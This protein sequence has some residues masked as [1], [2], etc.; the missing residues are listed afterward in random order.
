MV[1]DYS[2]SLLAF[3]MLDCCKKHVSCG[4]AATA[5][6][7]WTGC[8]HSV[9]SGCRRSPQVVAAAAATWEFFACSTRTTMRSCLKRVTRV[10]HRQK[11]QTSKALL[12]HYLG[13][14]CPAKLQITSGVQSS[15]TGLLVRSARGMSKVVARIRGC[16]VRPYSASWWGYLSH[17][18][19]DTES[20]LD[21]PEARPRESEDVNF[22]YQDRHSSVYGFTSVRNPTASR[23]SKNHL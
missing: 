4:M 16:G 23:S 15:R 2:G 19:S 3:L 10:Q 11:C 7:P 5:P 17:N 9:A 22:T 20:G 13:N 14:F 12:F 1:D 6:D 18:A 8:S 21:V